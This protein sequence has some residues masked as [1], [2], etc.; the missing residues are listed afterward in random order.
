MH[1]GAKNG[2]ED[3]GEGEE[4]QAAELATAYEVFGCVG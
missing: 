3:G 1:A 4:E 2:E